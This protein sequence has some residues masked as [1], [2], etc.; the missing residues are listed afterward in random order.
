M[1]K[2][3]Y[4]LVLIIFILLSCGHLSKDIN[5]KAPISETDNTTEISREYEKMPLGIK[6]PIFRIDV[7]SNYLSAPLVKESFAYWINNFKDDLKALLIKNG[8]YDNRSENK[9]YIM[10]V[11]DLEANAKKI[12][13]CDTYIPYVL[14]SCDNKYFIY[15]S[16]SIIFNFYMEDNFVDSKRIDITDLGRP[17]IVSCNSLEKINENSIDLIK[18]LYVYLLDYLSKKYYLFYIEK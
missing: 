13:D 15:I 8:I 3:F 10:P 11:F 1:Y 4:I 6:E 14:S 16:G 2:K 7:K 5:K 18:N 17:N 9:N 12:K